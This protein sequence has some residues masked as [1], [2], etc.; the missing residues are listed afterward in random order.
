MFKGRR[1]ILTIALEDTNERST[2]HTEG[3]FKDILAY[4]KSRESGKSPAFP[5][6]FRCLAPENTPL[7]HRGDERPKSYIRTNAQPGFSL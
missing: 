5:Y 4:G 1:I 6:V 2:R 3:M 7:V